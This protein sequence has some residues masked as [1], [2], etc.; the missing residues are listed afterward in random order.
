M[1]WSF[2][3][4]LSIGIVLWVA[5]WALSR[6]RLCRLERRMKSD[7][8]RFD[9]ISAF[10]QEMERRQDGVDLFGKMGWVIVLIWV[11]IGCYVLSEIV[12]VKGAP[13]FEK[14]TVYVPFIYHGRL[15]K[16]ATSYVSNEPDVELTIY[17][18]QFYNGMFRGVPEGIEV[19]GSGELHKSRHASELSLYEPYSRHYVSGKEKNKMI[20]KWYINE[21]ASAQAAMAKVKETMQPVYDAIYQSLH[22]DDTRFIPVDSM[23]L[24]PIDK[25]SE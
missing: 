18:V 20:T 7:P 14:D 24:T 15:C 11:L 2:E 19:V 21:T 1:E 6:W 12:V 3:D 17:G 8:H 5:L 4:L 13:P 16:P 10:D 25:Y 22:S 9:K 23:N